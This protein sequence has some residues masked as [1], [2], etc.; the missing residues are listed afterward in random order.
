M[1]F[2]VPNYSCLQNPWLEGYHLQ[3]PVLSVLNCIYWTPA[4]HCPYA[5][6]SHIPLRLLPNVRNAR[7]PAS[8]IVHVCNEC[9][10]EQL[11]ELIR[12]LTQS[13]KF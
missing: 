7:S 13:I 12:R 10:I 3:I 1:K 11:Q 6:D 5:T 8:T 2:L 4:R 9:S